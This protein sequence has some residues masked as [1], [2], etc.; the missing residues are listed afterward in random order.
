MSLKPDLIAALRTQL[1]DR[2]SARADEDQARAT[3]DAQAIADLQAAQAA[4]T[5][6]IAAQRT[7]FDAP[8][9]EAITAITTYAQDGVDFQPAVV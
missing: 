3:A 4:E 2:A 8:L 5:A 9:L 1:V 7:A 6:R